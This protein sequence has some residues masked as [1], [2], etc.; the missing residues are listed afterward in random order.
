VSEVYSLTNGK[1]CGAVFIND[2]LKKI[3]GEME[4]GGVDR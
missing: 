3:E 4:Y 2:I 1:F